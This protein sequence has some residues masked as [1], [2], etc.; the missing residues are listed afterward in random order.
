[1]LILWL[2]QSLLLGLFMQGLPRNVIAEE[3]TL[4]G[5]IRTLTAETNEQTQAEEF[6]KLV[7]VLR[8]LFNVK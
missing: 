1:M 8:N 4:S 3:A 7:K 6:A 2:G 5:T